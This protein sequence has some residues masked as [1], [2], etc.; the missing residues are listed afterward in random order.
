MSLHR[1]HLLGRA[2]RSGL[3]SVKLRQGVPLQDA[4]S[5][6]SGAPRTLSRAPA[7]RCRHQTCVVFVDIFCRKHLV[8]RPNVASFRV[9]PGS[10]S[11]HVVTLPISARAHILH[12]KWLSF[13]EADS[14]KRDEQLVA[15]YAQEALA[16]ATTDMKQCILSLQSWEQTLIVAY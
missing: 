2:C 5:P 1:H 4:N 6:N 3:I 16:F 9:K 13:G 14:K 15:L 8:E 10:F 11:S 12:V 7:F